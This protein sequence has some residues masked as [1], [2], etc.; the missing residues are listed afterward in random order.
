V[1]L[2]LDVTNDCFCIISHLSNKA[3]LQLEEIFS[4]VSIGVDERC[5]NK[6]ICRETN[7]QNGEWY[8]V[9]INH[10]WFH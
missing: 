7:D 1:V 2:L 8:I 5:K 9:N 10:I 4:H 3:V 6:T